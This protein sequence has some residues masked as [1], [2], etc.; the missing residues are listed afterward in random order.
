MGAIP[1]D[2]FNLNRFWE[3]TPTPLKYILVIAI[4]LATSYFIFSKKMDDNHVAEIET[5]KTGIVATYELID[6]FEE[7]RQEQDE[8]NK[9]VLDYLQNLHTLV[10]ELNETTNRKFDMILNSGNQNAD[11]IIEKIMLLN[12]SFE[13]LSK[14]YEENI[15]EPNL[16]DN[17]VKKNLEFGGELDAIPIDD[18]GYFLDEKTGLRISDEYGYIRYNGSKRI[19]DSHPIVQEIDE[20]GYVRDMETGELVIDEDGYF[21]KFDK[22]LRKRIKTK[23]YTEEIPFSIGAKKQGGGGTAISD[24]TKV[25]Y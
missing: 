1:L 18:D 25:D 7:F 23:E 2:K 14:A 6:N 9:E 21:T 20:Y 24:T 15:E 16:D 19:F 17:K 12:E 3:K 8:Y 11:Q 10:E 4:L 5:M 22:K 13:K